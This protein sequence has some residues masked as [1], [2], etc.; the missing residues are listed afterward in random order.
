MNNK[1]NLNNI[2]INN[3][4]N[5]NND[6]NEKINTKVNNIDENDDDVSIYLGEKGYTIYKDALTIKEQQYIRETLTVRPYIPKSPVQPPSFPIYRESKLKLYVPR[7]FGYENYGTPEESRISEGDDINVPFNGELRDYQKTVVDIYM[8]R[9]TE[10]AFGGGGLLDLAPGQGKTV[11]GL[12]IIS[13]IGKKALI[14]VHKGFLLNQW[15]ERIEQYLPSARVGKIQGQIIDIDNKDIVIGML[16]SLSMKE[17]PPE[18]FKSFGITVVDEVHHI[19]SEV[20]SRSL[21]KLVTKYTLGLSGTMQRKDGLTK[22]FKMYLGEVLFKNPSKK[23]DKVI[24][25]AVEFNTTDADFGEVET[26]YRGN[27]KYSTMITKLCKFNRRSEHI[28]KVI[29]QEL[30]HNEN[31]Q[32]IVLAHNKNLLTYLHDAIKSRDIASVGYYLGGMKEEHLKQSESKKIIIA[33]YAMASEGLDIPSLTTLVFATPKTDITQSVGRILRTK[34]SNPLVID[35]VDQHDIFKQQWEKR[36]AYYIKNNYKVLYST[37]YDGNVWKTKYDP[38]NPPIKIKS[39]LS[40]KKTQG[41]CLVQ[42][43]LEQTMKDD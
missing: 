27:I 41:K 40:A 39:D 29:K 2:K 5:T 43:T 32:I 23:D 19:S 42:L 36:N 6:N 16:Q 37:N 7:Y 38:E 12:N 34:H 15:I 9:V 3:A 11:L 4:N 31:Q 25:K 24:V 21:L 18:L 30:E 35:I 1:S 22:V 8:K 33:T 10:D 13:R 26:D 17:Y 28:L 20:F 14:I